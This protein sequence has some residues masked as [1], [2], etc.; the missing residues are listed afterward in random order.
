[1][2]FHGHA[3]DASIHMIEDPALLEHLRAMRNDISVVI[4]TGTHKGTGSTK[5]LAETLAPEVLHT[6]EV[7]LE[8]FIEAKKNL[9][10]F[11]FVRPHW[12]C[13]VGIEHAL[14]W[15]QNDPALLHPENYPDVWIDFMDDPIGNYSSEVRGSSKFRDYPGWEGEDLLSTLLSMYR[16]ERPLI[17]LDSAG[18]MGWLE[19][20]IMESCMMGLDYTLLLDDVKHVKHFRS[21]AWIENAKDFELIDQRG[22]WA[23]ARHTA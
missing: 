14:R 3:P 11:P 12:G 1:M 6:V 4:E 9:A 23:L 2:K 15:M 5:F 22:K 13:T 20:Q 16:D 10:R 7:N 18:G 8:C 19:F 21:L 17:V